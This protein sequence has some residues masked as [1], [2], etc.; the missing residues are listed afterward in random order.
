MPFPTPGHLSDTEIK[1]KLL[2]SPALSGRFFTTSTTWEAHSSNWIILIN[3]SLNLLILSL[4]NLNM[5]FSL[6]GEFYVSVA[7][8]FNSRI[9]VFLKI[10]FVF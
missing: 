5:Q 3:L 7:I 2:A 1:P 10:A 4:T 6:S 9:S 8:F